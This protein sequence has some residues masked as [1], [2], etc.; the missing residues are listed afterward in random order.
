MDYS[1]S[2]NWI[3]WKLFLSQNTCFR[4]L[5]KS[6]SDLPISNLAL[7]RMSR[8]RIIRLVNH[9]DWRS[10][11]CCPPKSARP[12]FTH[13]HTNL[14]RLRDFNNIKLWKWTQI[15]HLIRIILLELDHMKLLRSNYFDRFSC[16]IMLKFSWL[17]STHDKQT[18]KQKPIRNTLNWHCLC[19][20]MVFQ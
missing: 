7:S 17:C 1:Y 8:H 16:N 18:N 19:Y 5:W 13:I 6:G 9:T 15:D 4:W 2:S 14:L 11:Y 12:L 3:L 20:I 10:S